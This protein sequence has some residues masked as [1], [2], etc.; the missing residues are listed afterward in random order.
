M[1]ID[2]LAGLTEI[3][4][5]ARCRSGFGE[6]GENSGSERVERGNGDVRFVDHVQIVHGESLILTEQLVN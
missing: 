2:L 4:G 1:V 5:E 6:G 3:D